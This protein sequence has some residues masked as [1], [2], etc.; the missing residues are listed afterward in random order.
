[1]RLIR[2]W[3]MVA[4]VLVAC[5]ESPNRSA[6]DRSLLPSGDLDKP[7]DLGKPG[8]P[9]QSPFPT[10]TGK[11]TWYDANGDGACS[12]GPSPGNLMVAAMNQPQYLGS[13]ACGACARVN[14]PSGSVTVR[15]VDLCPECQQGHIDLSQQA[16]AKIAD[17]DLGEV[18][19][20]WQYLPCEVSGPIAYHFKEGSSEWWTA[21]QVRNTRYA[22]RTLEAKQNGVF[23]SVNRED[24]N[25]F[26][27]AS[28][29]GPGPY[30][31]RVVDILGHQ[32]VDTNIPHQEAQTVPGASQFPP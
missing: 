2:G 31:L 22:V 28:G 24:Y 10:V 5:N 7:G 32:L 12:F 18:P 14:G 25:F 21:I 27:Q 26:V 16:F 1:M 29:L 19:V 11:A 13:E 3:A 15:V 17:P 30:E 8:E 4:L 23:V 6:V 20:T 9:S